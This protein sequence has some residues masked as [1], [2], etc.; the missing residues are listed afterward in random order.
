MRWEPTF[1]Q[2]RVLVL[3]N[4][5]KILVFLPLV[6][7]AAEQDYENFDLPAKP[8]VAA[9]PE[10]KLAY[11]SSRV[12]LRGKKLTFKE[13]SL[14]HQTFVFAKEAF[15][16]EKRDEAIKLL[17]QELDSGM[18]SNRDNMLLRLG[19]LY[20]EK[21]MELSYREN[22]FFSKQLQ[23][24]ETNKP[25]NPKLQA[26]R[27]NNSRSQ[28]Y[29]KD[30]LNL[31][32]G[33][34]KEFPKHPKMDEVSFF[35][36]F[37]ELEAGNSKKGLS[38][39]ERVIKNHPESR[40]WQE[41]VLY[42]GDYYFDNH[43]FKDASTRYQML[44]NRNSN[45]RDYAEYKL[46]WCELNTGDPKKALRSMKKLIE[47]LDR[48][49]ET[50]KFNL[51]DQALK[52]LVSFYVEA[53]NV[54][55]AVAFFTEMQS[56]DKALSNLRLLADMYRSKAKD[57]A[58]ISAYTK[59]ISEFPDGLDTPNLYLGLYESQARIGKSAPAT[60]TLMTA[61][62]KFGET[63]DWAKNIPEE[64]EAEKKSTIEGLASEAAKAAY[65]H[66]NAAQK[67]A[68]RGHY[69]YAL[70]IYSSLLSNFPSFPDRKKIAFFQGEALFN[71]ERWLDASESYMVAAQIPPK[72]KLSAESVYNALLALDKLTAAS[73]KLNR[74]DKNEQK[75]V[76]LK[77][78]EIPNAEKKFIEVGEFYIKEYPKGDRVVDVEFRIASIYYRR[79]HFDDAQTAFK[80]LALKYPDHRSATTAAHI[81]LDIDNIKK[82]YASLTAHAQEF[83]AVKK[84]GDAGFRKELAE[85]VGEI[86]FKGIETFENNQDWAKAGSGYYKFY[87]SN[88]SSPLA[89]KA[90][91]NSYVSYQ[92][93]GD[94]GKTSEMAK[95]FLVKFP[96]SSYSGKI[97]LNLAQNSEKQADFE[98]AQKQ[99]QE[100]YKRFPEDKEAKKALYNA[101]VYA[102]L[103]EFNK[104][105]LQLYD[106]YSKEA[107][108][109][110]KELRAIDISRAKLY[111]KEKEMD[112]SAAIYMKLSKES[113]SATERMDILAELAKNY[114]KAGMT[115]KK[116]GI[117]S[118]IKKI[119]IA[120]KKVKPSGV[121]AY[122][123]AESFFKELQKEKTKYESIKLRFPESDLI[124]LMK[125]KQKALA[126]LAQSYDE[127]I[128][129]GVPDWGVASLFEKS[130]AYENYVTQ[131]R[132]LKIPGRYKPEERQEAETALKQID[133]KQIVPLEQKAQEILSVCAERAAQFHVVSDYAK[134]CRDKAK[135]SQGQFEPEGIRPDAVYWSTRGPKEGGA[136]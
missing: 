107:K 84:L 64:K 65:F 57:E 61:L 70:K 14:N 124:Y 134:K 106:T 114:E 2:R 52:D 90:L 77:P 15:I 109:T 112:K 128:E 17:R 50:G 43:K 78:E 7:V 38:Y 11:Q 29:L 118:E 68:N 117:V 136:E 47:R 89:E 97:M 53:E 125:R 19:Q 102:E 39:L 30:A 135:K 105:A 108:P 71:L 8:A 127:E 74:Y 37:V 27:L 85:I 100:F 87:E 32:Y 81:V 126:K 104:L 21:Y 56:K 91:Y 20:A 92:K 93:L 96:K 79:H 60:K 41:A 45:L 13:P 35:I 119:A 22:E 4:F 75:N 3:T 9:I 31:F 12:S 28:K 133:A 6:A 110:D 58:A 54:D 40:K 115:S 130:M 59:L 18:K 69:D 132:S 66:H 67:S 48:N 101:A 76:D 10:S 94:S 46:A 26:P 44:F 16:A 98:T 25:G 49:T 122:Y 121:A 72:D 33:L 111:R 88:P 34:E 80:N 63:S 129:R 73:S 23:E 51:R 113:K 120:N 82:D 103:L 86:D 1:T 116:D 5:T 62:E 55:D 36:G 83:T 99:Y 95:L 123:L 131:F 24:Y 42:T